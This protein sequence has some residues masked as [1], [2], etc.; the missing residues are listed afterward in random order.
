M[1]T[2]PLFSMTRMDKEWKAIKMFARLKLEMNQ[3]RN[4][5]LAFIREVLEEK[6]TALEVSESYNSV[7][8]G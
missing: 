1:C 5:F 8:C 7:H 4:D 6:Q 3:S 2:A